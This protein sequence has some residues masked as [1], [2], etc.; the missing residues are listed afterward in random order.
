M[1]RFLN[2]LTKTERG[3]K[4][5]SIFPNAWRKVIL[6]SSG[7][8]IILLLPVFWMGSG[9]HGT[10]MDTAS[11]WAL[12]PFFIFAAITVFV[13]APYYWY[14]GTRKYSHD[15]TW[16]YCGIAI[17][18]SFFPGAV[19]YKLFIP[20]VNIPITEGIHNLLYMLL[21]GVLYLTVV[22]TVFKKQFEVVKEYFPLS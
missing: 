16:R 14:W 15:D 2:F 17:I 22:K 5:F 8:A 11:M 3:K 20:F 1:K 13:Y 4:I 10:W 21:L 6:A 12:S 9:Y 18:L 19:F 7:M